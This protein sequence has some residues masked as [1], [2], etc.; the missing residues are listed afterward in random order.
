MFL[1]IFFKKTVSSVSLCKQK[2]YKKLRRG[3]LEIFEFNNIW[4]LSYLELFS[5]IWLSFEWYLKK[6]GEPGEPV[7]REAL[8]G[9][10]ER[11]CED[12]Q[13]WNGWDQNYKFFVTFSYTFYK[14]LWK[15]WDQKCFDNKMYFLQNPRGRIEWVRRNC[16]KL[17]W[18]W[19]ITQ[20]YI[21]QNPP[22]EVTLLCQNI[23][24]NCTKI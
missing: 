22:G 12:I 21:L 2:P 13:G 23:L 24:Q 1:K 10:P 18:Y 16:V 8:Q 5:D 4:Y 3:I 6:D 7:W 17:Q 15:M 11:N 19:N 9:T 20:L 14:I